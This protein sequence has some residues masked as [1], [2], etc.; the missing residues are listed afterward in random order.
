MSDSEEYR[1]IETPYFARAFKRFAKRHQEL[2]EV[3]RQTLWTL[4][5][6]PFDP[7]LRLHDLQGRLKGKQAVRLTYA[8][9]IVLCVEVLEHDVVLHVIGTHDEVYG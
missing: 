4:K 2:R 1:L 6:N 3:M 9:R 7:S 8:Y 5:R